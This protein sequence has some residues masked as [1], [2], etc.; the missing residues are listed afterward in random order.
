VKT[1]L[2]ELETMPNDSSRWLAGC[3]TSASMI[4]EH[5]R[6]ER[7]R[8]SR[9]RSDHVEEENGKLTAMMNKEGFK[10]A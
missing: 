2:Y 1:Y 6:E 9:P 5:M 8:S 3:A 4:E 10:F 7:T